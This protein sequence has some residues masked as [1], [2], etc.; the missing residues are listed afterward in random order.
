MWDIQMAAV[1]ANEW[2]GGFLRS[3]GGVERNSFMPITVESDSYIGMM[4]YF[5]HFCAR[6]SNIQSQNGFAAS[7]NID[8][9]AKKKKL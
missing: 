4:S 1:G 3:T 5:C 6:H 8:S 2:K 7:L 9:K